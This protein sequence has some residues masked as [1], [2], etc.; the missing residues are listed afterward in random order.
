MPMT[1]KLAY[2]LGLEDGFSDLC[3]NVIGFNSQEAFAYRKGFAAGI[4][5]REAAI[6]QGY[7]VP[8]EQQFIFYEDW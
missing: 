6:A 5:N 4:K 2:E 1:P 7:Q 3:G 8:Q